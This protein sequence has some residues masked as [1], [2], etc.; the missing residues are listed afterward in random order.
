MMYLLSLLLLLATT[1]QHVSAAAYNSYQYDLTV[2]QFTPDGRLLQVE[3][4]SAA[5][6]HSSPL[7]IARLNDDMIVLMSSKS[8]NKVQERLIILPESDTVVA[9]SGI[10]ADSLALLQTAQKESLNHRRMHG[11]SLTATQIA[12]VVSSACQSHAFGGGLRC[13][14]STLVVCGCQSDSLVIL[15]SDPS[16]A[17]Q[18]LTR[19][20]KQTTVIGGAAYRGGLGIV[21]QRTLDTAAELGGYKDATPFQRIAKIISILQQ[22]HVKSSKN[23]ETDDLVFE[24]ALV[25]RTR[26]AYKL[27]TDQVEK[28]Q[29]SLL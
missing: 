11:N 29:S 17:L 16:G 10:L 24:V 13:Y 15:Q 27:S 8:D 19:L 25:S 20:N 21:V 2:P 26:G 28:L 6:D 7:V 22:E 14:G 4:A 5:A 9:I 23:A 3:Y 12:N 18:D 1:I